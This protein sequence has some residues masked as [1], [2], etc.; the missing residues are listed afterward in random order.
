MKESDYKNA[1]KGKKKKDALKR[2]W[3]NRDFEIELYWKRAT[4]F[5]T[6]IAAAFIGY[7]T[8]V[9]TAETM[10]SSYYHIEYLIICIGFV[11]SISWLLVNLGSKRWQE[12]WESHID[13]LEDDITGP[14]YKIIT[15]P[16]SYSV[17]KIN[18]I[19]S[20]F[21]SGIWFILGIRSSLASKPLNF[22]E[23][24]FDCF[25]IILTLATILTSIILAFGY[26]KSRK[27]IKTVDFIKRKTILVE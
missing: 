6:L 14:I 13:M 10:D 8:L 9:S 26:G 5:W 27:T 20:V 25:W 24:S 1:F 15:R 18:F 19:V 17:T 23:S 4:Y 21:I 7:I 16:N 2:A 22:V 11:F 3:L 12:N